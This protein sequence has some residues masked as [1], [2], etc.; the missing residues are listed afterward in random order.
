MASEDYRLPCDDNG[1]ESKIV[2]ERGTKVYIPLRAVH[3]D[4]EIYPEPH[5]FKPERFDPAAVQERHPLAFLG[6]GDGPRNCIGMRFG[7]MQSKG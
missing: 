2:L 6:F 3:Y 1:A 7:R 5:K 4:P